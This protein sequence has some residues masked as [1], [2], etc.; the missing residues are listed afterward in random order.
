[1]SQAQRKR[2]KAPAKTKA[3]EPTPKLDRPQ[4]DDTLRNIDK[5]IKAAQKAKKKKRKRRICAVCGL[6]GCDIGPF[7]YQEIE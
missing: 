5:A 4:T 2:G 1:M 6:G 3:A 7:K